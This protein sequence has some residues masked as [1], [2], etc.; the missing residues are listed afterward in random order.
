MLLKTFVCLLCSVTMALD[1]CLKNG[2]FLV[3]QEPK[4]L[5]LNSGETAI[6][7]CTVDPGN[8]ATIKVKTFFFRKRFTKLM[9]IVV[10]ST[11]IEYMHIVEY[12]NRLTYS[13]QAPLFTLMLKNVTHDDSDLYICDAILEGFKDIIGEGTFIF[14]GKQEVTKKENETEEMNVNETLNSPNHRVPLYIIISITAGLFLLLA[15]FAFVRYYK[16]VSEEC[17]YI[18]KEI[19]QYLQTNVSDKGKLFHIYGHSATYADIPWL[20]KL[21]GKK[22]LSEN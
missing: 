13:G 18:L 21:Y 5:L 15:L 10:Q 2:S 1:I 17:L 3:K 11:H 7:N 22:L 9:T 4:Q 16:M 14:V 19:T 6:I 12:K 8:D 20:T